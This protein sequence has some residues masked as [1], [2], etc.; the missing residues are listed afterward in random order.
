MKLSELIKIPSVRWIGGAFIGLGAMESLCAIWISTFLVNEKEMASYN[1]AKVIMLYY[2][3][4]TLGRLLSGILADKLSSWKLIKI[5]QGIT[6][7]AI[8]LLLLPLSLESSI[9]GL[10]LIGLDISP[11]FP[12]LIHLTPENFGKDISQSVMGTQIA[13]CYAATILTPPFFGMIAELFG[14]NLFP[15]TLFIAFIVMLFSIVC[16]IKWLKKAK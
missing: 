5:G 8:L 2:I 3:G 12:N 14:V 1:A 13:A 16:L 6:I 11:I 9:L 15:S 10:F 4:M 7:L